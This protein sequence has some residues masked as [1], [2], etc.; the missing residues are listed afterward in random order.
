MLRVGGDCGIWDDPSIVSGQYVS[1]ELRL[2]SFC[3]EHSSSASIPS[4]WLFLLCWKDIIDTV[5][6]C[7]IAR[8]YLENLSRTHHLL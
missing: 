6:G 2:S 4:G 1:S 5:L 7:T 8:S 3:A